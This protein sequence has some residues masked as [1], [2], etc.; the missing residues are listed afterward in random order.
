MSC[1]VT[2]STTK[3]RLRLVLLQSSV[4]LSTFIHGRMTY[5]F[6]GN[7]Y[8][9]FVQYIAYMLQTDWVLMNKK[10][11]QALA[12]K[13]NSKERALREHTPSLAPLV[14][15]DVVQVQNQTGNHTIKWDKSGVVE[16]GLPFDQVKVQMDDT[17]NLSA[18][19]PVPLEDQGAD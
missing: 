5:T 12:G 7:Q 8:F 3:E 19:S 11:D 13:Q 16:M 15:G 9:A 10:R 2:V 6:G 18:E 1:L 17:D 4:V 14:V